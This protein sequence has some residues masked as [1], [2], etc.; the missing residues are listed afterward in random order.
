LHSSHGHQIL[1]IIYLNE[2]TMSFKDFEKTWMQTFITAIKALPG[3]QGIP[4]QE[5][6]LV[7]RQLCC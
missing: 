4:G 5:E 1:G 2:K 6:L 7:F 3:A